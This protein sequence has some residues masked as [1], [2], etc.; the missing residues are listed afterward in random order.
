[1]FEV[2]IRYY[3]EPG[4]LIVVDLIYVHSREEAQ[5]KCDEI[6]KR[7]GIKCQIGAARYID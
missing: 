7:I 5:E 4:H 3:D 6:S 2:D 1:M